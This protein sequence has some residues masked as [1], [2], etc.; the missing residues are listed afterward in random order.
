MSEDQELPEERIMPFEEKLARKRVPRTVTVPLT[1]D[2]RV[3]GAA[4][5]DEEGNLSVVLNQSRVGKQMIRLFHEG[6]LNELSLN[7]CLREGRQVGAAGH[8]KKRNGSRP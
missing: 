1:F 4:T 8:R 3:A 5:I 7:G 6:Y 2:Q